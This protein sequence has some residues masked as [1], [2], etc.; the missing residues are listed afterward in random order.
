MVLN[1][2][3]YEEEYLD[4]P[5]PNIRRSNT[6][7]EIMGK[8]VAQSL[9][10][11]YAR[12]NAIFAMFCFENK[13]FR[14][15]LLETWFIKNVGA[16][17]RPSD[18]LQY[19]REIMLKCRPEDNNCPLILSNVTFNHFSNFLSQRTS[20]RGKNKGKSMSLGTASYHQAKSA[21]LHLF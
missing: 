16:C 8:C 2:E 1:N 14:D 17:L 10:L 6:G 4:E 20:R 7:K 18:K 19:A 21:L 11:K 12:Q 3:G 5:P 15:T 9:S 13:E